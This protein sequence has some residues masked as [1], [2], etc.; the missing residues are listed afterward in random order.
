MD[1]VNPNPYLEKWIM[2]P[3][4]MSLILLCLV[5]LLN[6]DTT[7]V[8]QGPGSSVG[9]RDWIVFTTKKVS[10]NIQRSSASFRKVQAGENIYYC[11]CPYKEPHVFQVQAR[12]C[13]YVATALSSPSMI[14]MRRSPAQV[15]LPFWIPWLRHWY[16]GWHLSQSGG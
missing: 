10:N 11:G 12:F 2:H 4:E 3:K 6:T 14:P 13:G 9:E 16:S 1:K 8:L 5:P 15:A 7:E